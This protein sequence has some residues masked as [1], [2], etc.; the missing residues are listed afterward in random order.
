MSMRQSG[1]CSMV[2]ITRNDW[3]AG[4][5]QLLHNASSQLA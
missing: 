4:L 5:Q 2:H 1:T 3:H